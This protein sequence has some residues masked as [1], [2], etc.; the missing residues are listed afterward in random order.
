LCFLF[1]PRIICLCITPLAHRLYYAWP[2]TRLAPDVSLPAR[3][4]WPQ[5]KTDPGLRVLL[6]CYGTYG[7]LDLERA[8]GPD[9][10]PPRG[11][12]RCATPGGGNGT[13]SRGFR[14][15]PSRPPGYRNGRMEAAYGKSTI[16]K[17]N[18]R[19]PGLI[20]QYSPN[21]WGPTRLAWQTPAEFDG[22]NS[23]R[24][25]SVSEV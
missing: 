19:R 15:N 9:C 23:L 11:I 6:R 5:D 8:R 4:L 25:F 21:A 22:L 13:P 12:I 17:G 16:T 3:R 10:F 20:T 14:P 7:S 2:G 24:H 18:A 1:V